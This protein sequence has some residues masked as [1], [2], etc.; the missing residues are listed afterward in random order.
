M[1]A[2]LEPPSLRENVKIATRL[3]P[4][5]PPL[6]LPGPKVSLCH[7]N[8][9]KSCLLQF[10]NAF[11]QMEASI[12]GGKELQCSPRKSLG[13]AETGTRKFC[14][15]M[16]LYIFKDSLQ[17]FMMTPGHC[18]EKLWWW[19][20]LMMASILLATEACHAAKSHST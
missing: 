2:A 7:S 15:K 19:L 6:R 20:W 5:P 9:L 14:W 18:L 17:I 4:Q 8:L 3:P 16:Y 12:E 11:L 10:S 13:F 1:T